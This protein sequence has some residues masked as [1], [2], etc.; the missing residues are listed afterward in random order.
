MDNLLV[1]QCSNIQP[2]AGHKVCNQKLPVGPFRLSTHPGIGS[3]HEATTIEGRIIAIGKSDA[4]SAITFSAMAFVNVY[5]LGK[6][7]ITSFVLS[8]PFCL[9]SSQILISSSKVNTYWRFQN[10]HI[11]ILLIFTDFASVV[12]D[13]SHERHLLGFDGLI[14]LLLQESVNLQ[15][16]T[17]GRLDDGTNKSST[18]RLMFQVFFFS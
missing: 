4:L 9:A 11:P 3:F 5:V 12:R 17:L 7:P 16:N 14:S 10:K 2:T 1:Y 8:S 18:K 6:T 15:Y 13:S